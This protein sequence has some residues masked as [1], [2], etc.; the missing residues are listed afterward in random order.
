VLTSATLSVGG[1]FDYT[2]HRL[3]LGN[4]G[5]ELVVVSPFDFLSQALTL[6]PEGIPAHDEPEYHAAL[7]ALVAD[8]GERL[9]GRTLVLFTGYGPLRRLHGPGHRRRALQCRRG[10]VR[11]RRRPGLIRPTHRDVD[12]PEYGN[13]PAL[14]SKLLVRQLGEQ[15]QHLV[16]ST[17]WPWKENCDS[18]ITWGVYEGVFGAL[19]DQR[20]ADQRGASAAAWAAQNGCLRA[21]KERLLARVWPRAVAGTLRSYHYDP[22]TGAFAMDASAAKGSPESIVYLPPEVTGAVESGGAAQLRAVQD[23]ADGGR[24]AMVQPLGGAYSVRVTPAPLRLAA[25]G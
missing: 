20:C 9:G 15:E 2:R 22:D 1:S 5:E 16:G 17:Y 25:C 19:A 3:G 10:M 23:L 13:E 4:E 21:G 6:L 24:L 11:R 14:D 18:G 8:I 12:Q 7:L